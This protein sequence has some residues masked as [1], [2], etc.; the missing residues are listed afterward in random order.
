MRRAIGSIAIVVATLVMLGPAAVTAAPTPSRDASSGRPEGGLAQPRGLHFA[1]RGRGGD[2]VDLSPARTL[3]RALAAADFDEDG[4]PDL[5]AGFA[6]G[7]RGRVAL[8]S[9]DPDAIFPGQPVARARR[10]ADHVDPDAVPPFRSIGAVFEIPLAADLLG[11]GDFDNDGH[12]DVVAAAAG[13]GSLVLL[14]GDGRG[15][16]AEPIERGLPGRL[17]GMMAGEINRPDGL[18][19]VVVAVERQGRSEILVFEGAEGAWK[20][21]PES[22]RLPAPVTMLAIADLNGDFQP[23]LV[24]GIKEGIVV[25]P[26]RDRRLSLGSVARAAAPPAGVERHA[27]GFTPVRAV[28]GR[29]GASASPMLAMLGDDGE[30]R[31]AGPGGLESAPLV[32]YGR[33][34]AELVGARLRAGAGAGP[35][36]GPAAGPVPGGDDL[37]TLDASEVTVRSVAAGSAGTDRA[38]AVSPGST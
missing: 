29:F 37:L 8:L 24:A 10:A 17:T 18:A 22:V 12:M 7:R 19:D 35:D 25:V 33:P 11:A 32:G 13:G 30:L 27:L 31:L 21:E 1:F 34:D 38:E 16:F 15:G 28:A 23:D 26:G 4:V 36:A 5:V 6:D 20:A 2:P 3:P 14:R 9:G